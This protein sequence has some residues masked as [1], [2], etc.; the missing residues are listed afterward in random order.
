MLVKLTT[1][2]DPTWRLP[3]PPTAILLTSAVDLDARVEDPNAQVGGVLV[4]PVLRQHKDTQRDDRYVLIRL[5]I[6]HNILDIKL[7]DNS[8]HA[9]PYTIDFN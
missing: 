3:P 6:Y 8:L 1:A 9:C 7:P 5:L 4:D 2:L